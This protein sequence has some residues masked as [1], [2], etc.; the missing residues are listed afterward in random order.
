[1][2]Q[3]IHPAVGFIVLL[4][5]VFSSCKKLIEIDPPKNEIITE[6]VFSDSL[7]ASAAVTGIYANI[8]N[9]SFDV[10]P[11][12]GTMSIYTGLSADDLYHTRGFP[13]ED[14]FFTNSIQVNP[15][16][17]V[18]AYFWL[19]AYKYI[20]QAN[21]CIEGLSSSSS[22]GQGIRDRLIGE[23][24]FIR[25]YLYFNL[26]NLY[27]AVPLVNST[28][29]GTNASMERTS[30][31][32]VYAAIESDLRSAL[33]LLPDNSSSDRTRP[34]RAAVQ[35]LLARVTLFQG[36]WEEAEQLANSVIIQ[37]SYQLEQDLNAVFLPASKEV[38]WQ[39][40]PVD[41]GYNTP[42]GTQFNPTPAGRP[43]FPITENLLNVFEAGD[44]RKEKWL[45]SKTVSSI[46]YNYPFK[47]K[48]RFDG[49]AAPSEYNVMLRLAEQYL[50]RAEARTRRN[51]LGDAVA[52]LNIV[53]GRAGLPNLPLLS[54]PDMLIALEQERRVELFAEEGHR[55]FDLKRTGRANPVLQP[56]KGSSWQTTDVLYPLPFIEISLNPYLVQN[57]GY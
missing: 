45:K 49:S 48:L 24:R 10:N 29:F 21:A 8:M 56:I 25:A 46:L 42:A 5:I 7:N 17:P 52:D 30:V 14:D 38:I 32:E 13:E 50:I 22:L 39:I 31:D 6:T 9:S 33:G 3:S 51:K 12:N 44:G 53:R 35:S 37:P 2:R 40:R 36:K 54:Q 41:P 16:N 57:P 19:S 34:G 15:D 4:T 43:R 23:C 28:N 18:N 11:G 20:Y 55:W 47:Y 26:L 27:G 1:M